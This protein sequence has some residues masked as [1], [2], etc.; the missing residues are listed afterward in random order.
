[1]DPLHA[2]LIGA[3][4]PG[5]VAAIVV[6]AL[7]RPWGVERSDLPAPWAAALGAAL[8]FGLAFALILAWPSFPPHDATHG[9]PWFALAAAVVAALP[10]SGRREAP[11]RGAAMALLGLAA[12]WVLVGPLAAHALSGGEA[13]L[14]VALIAATFVA[15]DRGLAAALS[16]VD[17]RGSTLALTIFTGGAA[18]AVM[19]SASASL[20]QVTGALAAATGALLALGLWRPAA[21][22][23]RAATGV[24]A[25]VVAP[26][27]W[28]TL[29]YAE[30]RPEVV[31]I[32]AL[33]P[34]AL[35]ALR[36]L[37]RGERKLLL[38]LAVPALITT[39]PVAAAAGLAATAY[40][41]EPAP[42]EPG[43]GAD[44][45]D[46]DGYDPNYGY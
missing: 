17:P 9:T 24:V 44:G 12:G 42:A 2:L 37:L 35:L 30:G 40:F 5:A 13:A 20:G 6:I 29:L 36:P 32:F 14:Y 19:L 28:G 1:M 43:D 33:T 26:N 41:A 8:G 46:E 4:A 22:D 7:R 18:A 10:L 16:G 3:V 45:V 23:A 27:L 11:L 34:L 25:A 31:A 21:G 38:A 15:L 39:V